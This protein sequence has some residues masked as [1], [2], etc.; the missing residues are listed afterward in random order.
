MTEEAWIGHVVV[1]VFVT[2]GQPKLCTSTTTSI[3]RDRRLDS[4]PSSEPPSVFIEPATRLLMFWSRQFGGT[5]IDGVTYGYLFRN[6]FGMRWYGTNMFSYHSR[7]TVPV[8]Q[9][10]GKP[11]IRG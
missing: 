2:L 10:N 11:T 1:V 7:F 6:G 8:R 3:R 5:R 9:M 4:S